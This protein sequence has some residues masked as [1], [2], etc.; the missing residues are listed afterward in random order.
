MN[1]EG[2][3][4]RSPKTMEASRPRMTRNGKIARLTRQ[5]PNG[6]KVNQGYSSLAKNRA[7]A[8]SEVG[9][10][11]PAEPRHGSHELHRLGGTPQRL[12]S[13]E[14]FRGADGSPYPMGACVKGVLSKP[15]C[16]SDVQSSL[17]DSTMLRSRFPPVNWRAIIGGSRGTNTRRL[18]G[19][20]ICARD[21]NSSAGW[22]ALCT[23]PFRRFG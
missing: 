16:A 14:S 4:T 19:F 6:F 9:R 11:V 15:S 8:V 3:K 5:R 7:R 17:R 1:R 13:P 10:S 2:A 12:A 22:P 23:R 20:S 21:C 18:L